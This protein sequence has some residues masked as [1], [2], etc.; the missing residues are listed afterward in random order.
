M[1]KPSGKPLLCKNWIL[2]RAFQIFSYLFTCHK[3]FHVTNIKF[4]INVYKEGNWFMVFHNFNEQ[5]SETCSIYHQS[6]ESIL[7]SAIF[8]C[9]EQLW[10]QVCLESVSTNSSCPDSEFS[11]NF[12]LQKLSGQ[13]VSAVVVVVVHRPGHIRNTF[14]PGS[15]WQ[16][17]AS[18]QDNAAT[19]MFH[20]GIVC[21]GWHTVLG[22]CHI[23]QPKTCPLP[24][25]VAQ[26]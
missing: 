4:C 12:V 20:V 26:Y 3:Y 18:T 15:C 9:S 11:A 8:P 6:A 16:K 19:T 1:N 2:Y 21:S 24:E 22:F 14:S 17:K 23:E 7:C 10:L 25:T 5:K 13:K